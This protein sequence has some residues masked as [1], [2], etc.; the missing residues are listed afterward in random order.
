M[1]DL[2]GGDAQD[3]LNRIDAQ[4][5]AGP[6]LQGQFVEDGGRGVGFVG[7]AKGGWVDCWIVG[8]LDGWL[9][10]GFM[11]GLLVLGVD[12]C[13]ENGRKDDAGRT[14]PDSRRRQPDPTRPGAWLRTL[15]PHHGH[16]AH[17]EQPQQG[18]ADHEGRAAALRPEAAQGDGGGQ[19]VH[20]LS[21]YITAGA[22]KINRFGKYCRVRG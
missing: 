19:I 7:F 2:L 6:G 5:A 9:S 16:T 18:H 10:F 12:E 8:S 1:P 17:Q 13:R 22:T 20:T 4:S 15:A 3:Q 14:G 21:R 11:M